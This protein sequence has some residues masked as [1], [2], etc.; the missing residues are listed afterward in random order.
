M[1]FR[2]HTQ[3]TAAF[4]L[5]LLLGSVV[6]VCILLLLSRSI[7]QLERVIAF[8]DVVAH[9]GVELEL[10]LIKM[11]DAMRGY[12]LNPSDGNELERKL[13]ADAEYKRDI[14]ALTA[15]S[16]E[17][18]LKELI[19]EA[20]DADDNVLDRL[21]NQILDLVHKG[22]PDAAKQRYRDEYLPL[23]RSQERIIAAMERAADAGAKEAYTAARQARDTA[24]ITTWVF[25][26]C[27]FGVGLILSG[28][29]ARRIAA[30]IVRMAKSVD[31]AARG[32]LSARLE[33]VALRQDEL[34]E[35]SRS[36]HQ[37]Y[38]YMAEMARVADSITAGDLTVEVAPRSKSDVFGLSLKRMSETLRGMVQRLVVASTSVAQCAEE[39]AQSSLS[40]RRGAE[41]QSSATEETSATMVEMA[42]QIQSLAKGS[43][44]LAVNVDQ[45]TS[46]LLRMTATITETARAGE[47]L[48]GSSTAAGA[49]L[50]RISQ[51]VEGLAARL[52]V[53]DEVSTAS[54]VDARSGSDRLHASLSGIG[55]RSQEIGT[56]IKVIEDIADQTNLLALNAAIEAARA[57]D[58]GRG[59]AV[60]ADEVRRL[61][62]RSVRATQEVAAIIGAVQKETTAAIAMST[63]VLST[64]LSS[65]DKAS[66]F[67]RDA[68]RATE[69]QAAGT[70][71]VATTAA[72]MSTTSQEI[73]AS[74]ADNAL[75]A[76]EIREAAVSMNQ[77]TQ[78]MSTGIAE[79]GT[80]GE[81]VV[82]AVESI[83][84]V[85][86]QHLVGAEQMTM[87]A[88][89]L[90]QEAEVLRRQVEVFRV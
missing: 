9:R 68:V 8:H 23:R 12:L 6:S 33:H 62:E 66:Q 52:R 89:S 20:G 59:F 36:I 27:L 29:L 3:L 82:K 4:A 34:G 2:I 31:A 41:S 61:A 14:E 43:S 24:R 37:M 87:A 79:Q 25:V 63:S 40:M 77:L 83:A 65:A 55:Q 54:V 38:D 74:I 15:L 26:L 50:H 48:V 81:L 19:R 69:E 76:G 51:S 18:E 11:S 75:R 53:V 56:I 72:R 10:D 47:R 30:P 44:A 85:A 71:E 46:S 1:K 45:T 84:T 49:T 73:A 39:I 57:G 32:D 88:K 60:V 64:M 80:S 42:G 17:G 7:D 28:L 90:A 13:E 70:N 22:N 35:L 67:V 21:E 58:A 16:P 78:Q 86:R 5:L